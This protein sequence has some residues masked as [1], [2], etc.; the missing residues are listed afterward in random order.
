M[1]KH[2]SILHKI[3]TL[4]FRSYLATQIKTLLG[5]PLS[6][7]EQ[8]PK[9]YLSP[10]QR[11]NYLKQLCHKGVLVSCIATLTGC[12]IF[13]VYKA[14]I[15]SELF[16]INEIIIENIATTEREKILTIV[17][18]A[19]ITSMLHPTG[20]ALRAKI[21]ELEWVRK[22]EIEKIWPSTL[23]IRIQEQVPLALINLAGNNN[24][25]DERLYYVNDHGD[26]F[27]RAN[28]DY[29]M[30]YPVITG[31]LPTIKE[32]YS[33]NEHPLLKRALQFLK[34]SKI[35]SILS[36]QSIS[37]INITSDQEIIVYLINQPV[38]IHLGHEKMS[39]CFKR[40]CTVLYDLEQKREMNKIRSITMDYL[41]RQILVSMNE[42]IR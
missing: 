40:L 2:T 19:S 1:Q 3:W 29:S 31:L 34:E 14:A 16:H 7:F 21:T 11:K 12:F 8:N 38:A 18:R 39:R 5:H 28:G 30:D 6:A 36:I 35:S 22:A 27:S 13:I 26:I 15:D 41:D 10:Y 20:A 32:D 42:P 23:T 9:D 17:K 33:T 25:N 24:N 37:E 4:L